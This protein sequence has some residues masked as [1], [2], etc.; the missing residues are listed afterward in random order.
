MVPAGTSILAVM[1]TGVVEVGV[2][3]V[4]GDRSHVAFGIVEEQETVTV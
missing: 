4:P 3:D 2:T 1:F